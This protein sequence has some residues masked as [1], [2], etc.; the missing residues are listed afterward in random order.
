MKNIKKTIKFI[1]AAAFVGTAVTGCKMDMLPLNDVV[2]ENYWTDKKDVESVMLSCYAG[3]QDITDN[4]AETNYVNQLIVWGETRSDNV[5]PGPNVNRNLAN[6]MK[7]SL[8]TTNP[9]CSWAPMYNVINRCNTVLY[10]A[11]QVAEKDPNY[12]ESDLNINIAECK[13]LRAMSYLTLI[14]TFKDVPFSLEPSIDDTQEYRLPQT[15]FET[16]L[17]A[18]IADIESCKNFPPIRYTQK[19]YNTAKITRAA[20][21]SLLAELYLWRASDKNLDPALQAQYYQQCINCCN[22]VINYKVQQKQANNIEGED[23]DK[24]IDKEVWTKYQIPLLAEVSSGEAGSAL[25]KTGFDVNFGD[26]RSFETIFEIT[27]NDGVNRKTN[28]VV[29]DLFGYSNGSSTTRGLLT[30]DKL[31][32]SVPTGNEYKDVQLFSTKADMRSIK[33]FH[34]TENGGFEIQK[35]VCSKVETDYNGTGDINFDQIKNGK[36]ETPR[37]DGQMYVN[38]IMYRL[39]EIVLFKAE[40]EIELAGLTST[41]ATTASPAAALYNDAY[42]MICAVYTRSCPVVKTNANVLPKRDNYK[43]LVEFETLLMN[44]RQREFLFEGKRYFDL[45]RQARRDGNTN[46]FIQKLTSKLGEGG[47]SVSIKMKQMDYMYMPILK[48]EKQAN[49]SLRQNSAYLDEE[50]I[51]NN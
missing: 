51:V 50:Q 21:Y 38:W 6:L 34:Y 10:Y 7:G 5:I 45:V 48:S 20:M 28:G 16:V 24:T 2:L 12:T 36:A 14:K 42:D 27:Y 4:K 39:A 9:F 1:A 29:G 22:W 47:A 18:L 44:E 15:P 35:Y 23:L 19:A 37:T 25:S 3:M 8:K 46:R 13:A 40:A 26:G 31:M 17:D 33:S 32:T 49:P 41:D 43:T 30:S 11:P